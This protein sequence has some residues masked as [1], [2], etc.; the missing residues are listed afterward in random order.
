MNAVIYCRVSSKEQVE[1][2]SLESQELACRDYAAQN[3][4]NVAQVFVE[5]GESAKFAD[6]TQLLALLA[7]CGKRGN[8]IHAL[9]VWKVDRLARNVGDHFNIKA[10]LMKLG[11][12]VISVTE[13]I[14]AKPEGKLLETILAGFAQFDNDI[15]AT[16]TVQGMQRKIQ[17]GIFPWNPPLGYKGAKAPGNKK[18]EPD[19]PDQPAF[20]LLQRGWQDFATGAYTKAQML[21]MLNTRGLR[22]RSGKPITN[23]FI[24]HLFA[25]L[26]YAG[27]IRDPWNGE[28]YA[29]RHLAMVNRETFDDVQ[30][31]IA[32]RNRTIPHQVER[33]EF[34]LRSFLHC[35]NCESPLT[36]SFSRGR[37]AIYPY[38]HCYA[39]ACDSHGNYPLKDAHDEFVAFLLQMNTN[40]HALAHLADRMR[41][42]AVAW[43]ATQT[44]L[45]EKRVAERQRIEAEQQQLIRMKMEDLITDDEFRSQ[46]I[47]LAERLHRAGNDVLNNVMQID[48][49]VQNLAA[50]SKP[51][52]HL[53]ETWKSLPIK[54]QRRF[55]LILLP[56]GY[57][58]GKVGTAEKG[59]LFSF[60][61]SSL[62][63]DT[64]V[65]P[66]VGESWNQLIEEIRELA[67]IFQ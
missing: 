41:R 66:P 19:V 36:G 65:V 50:I 16:R 63:E 10:S 34:P 4:L 45:A 1:G 60:L 39:H 59:H 2:T 26:F 61:H 47:I 43:D 11:V 42:M 24:D 17:E 52:M 27:V 38:Y 56:K 18:N 35:A 48:S 46:R 7:F 29:G 28:K 12:R 30:R 51:L 25:D 21:R 14:D 54:F 33:Q 22:L 53:A 32:R 15:R 49:A 58:Y 20:R 6:R 44:A 37:S 9:L 55:Q 13:P 40:R 31:I 62:P 8:N 67:M 5:R 64:Y 3:N 23:Q 57:V